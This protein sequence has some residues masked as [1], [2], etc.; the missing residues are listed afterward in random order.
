MSSTYG[1][2]PREIQDIRE[3][4][5]FRDKYICYFCGRDI[6]KISL[7]VSIHHIIPK[8]FLKE[9]HFEKDNLITICYQCHNKLEKLNY[10]L[11]SFVLNTKIWRLEDVG[12][13]IKRIKEEEKI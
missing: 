11:L 5:R 4:V 12:K 8:C 13:I 3:E 6:R 7:K 10:K 9:K 1:L 2:S